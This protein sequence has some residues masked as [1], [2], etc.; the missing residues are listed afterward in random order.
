MS[1]VIEVETIYR[2]VSRWPNDGYKM[3]RKAPEN[4]NNNNN[5]NIGFD[6]TPEHH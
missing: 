1:I 4:N 3:G 5:N 6:R 2:W